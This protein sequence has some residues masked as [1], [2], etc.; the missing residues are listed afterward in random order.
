M[1]IEK[2]KPLAID[3]EFKINR[4]EI[5]NDY[6]KLLPS[7]SGI[8]FRSSKL[9]NLNSE[10]VIK[11]VKDRLQLSFTDELKNVIE[12]SSTLHF[13]T[14]DVEIP[15]ELIGISD[16]L[17]LKH[18]FGI[19]PLSKRTVLSSKINESQTFNIL[20][21]VDTKENLPQTRVEIEKIC[22]MIDLLN[23]KNSKRISYVVLKGK[24]A[25]YANVRKNLIQNYFDIIHV[26]THTEYNGIILHD[27]ILT[28]TDIYKDMKTG[29]PWLVFMN[30][31]ES[32]V[33]IDIDPFE[34]YGEL[35]NL[36]ISFLA[37]GALSYIGTNCIINDEVASEIS[38]GF[39]D[40]L[41]KGLPLGECLRNSK[42]AFVNLHHDNLGA[43]AFRL[44][45]DP[46]IKRNFEGKSK[47]ND[48]VK[49][50]DYEL[51]ETRNLKFE[52]LEYIRRNKKSFDIRKCARDLKADAADI[53]NIISESSK[54]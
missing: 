39:Y 14:D 22:S 37:A 1:V 49:E 54:N 8:R 4:N 27:G 31:C 19:S 26:A 36:T 16:D 33:G 15:W 50:D 20:F 41:F 32:A 53:M 30:S 11:S 38:V 2:G 46:T 44:F 3:T 12:N 51:I 29:A 34:K 24:D 43:L 17:R 45:G 21:I 13:I 23:V 25:T 6:Q 28:P 48:T 10:H 7:I 42:N 40:E 18:S 5:I 47:V 9:E 35:S 52:V